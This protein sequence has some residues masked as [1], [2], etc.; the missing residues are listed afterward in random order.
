[1]ANAF[2]N[3]LMIVLLPEVKDVIT[4]EYRDVRMWMVMAV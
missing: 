1:M 4:T 2:L 3:A